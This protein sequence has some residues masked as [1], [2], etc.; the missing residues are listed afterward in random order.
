M[1]QVI[2]VTRMVIFPALSNR[3]LMSSCGAYRK[4]FGALAMANR[5]TGI[6]MANGMAESR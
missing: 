5:S 3:V 4:T 1:T 6:K 2:W